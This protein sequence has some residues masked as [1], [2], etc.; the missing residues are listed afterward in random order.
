MEV[1]GEGRSGGVSPTTKLIAIVILG[2]MLLNL[3][4]IVAIVSAVGSITTSTTTTVEATAFSLCLGG[5]DDDEE[6]ST[7]QASTQP[8]DGGLGE[9]QRR[10]AQ[11]YADAGYSRAATA[12]VMGNLQAESHFDPKL[13]EYGGGGGFGLAQWTPRSK[14]RAWFDA[15]GLKDKDDGDL[16]G[17]VKMLIS[18]AQSSFMD[19]PDWSMVNNIE[20]K[21]SAY[22][23]WVTAKDSKTATIAYMAGWERP[24]WTKR[25]EE[26]RVS[27][28]E[29]YYQLIGSISFKT[30]DGK[31]PDGSTGGG[32]SGSSDGSG[33]SD[34][35]GDAMGIGCDTNDR[36]D[37]INGYVEWALKTAKDDKVGYSSDPRKRNLNPDVDCSSF[38]HNALTRG[39]AF[40]VPPVLAFN[41]TNEAENLAKWGF[42][43]VGGK[44]VKI[45]RG[46]ILLKP[47]EGNEGHTEIAVNETTSVG[48]HGDNGHPEDGDQDGNE[49]SEAKLWKG[50]TEVWRYPGKDDDGDGGDATFG[51]VGGAPTNRH[52]FGW[53]CDTALRICHDGDFGRPSISWGGDY[54]CYWYWLARSFV[55][56]D[57][58]I[59]NPMT[60]W[61]G[62]LA[63]E[64]GTRPGWTRSDSPK[65]GAGVSFIL[66]SQG[67][68]HVAVVEKVES[69][70][71]GWKMMI[72]EGN[73]NGTGSWNSYN[74]RWLTKTQYEAGGGQGFFWKTS[75]KGM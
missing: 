13:G 62:Q 22:E 21:S 50:Y 54:Q 37:R 64:V 27:A 2:T 30:P 49:V 48:A 38:V 29:K 31:A 43:K 73:Y 32:P 17:Q 65:P 9:N 33:S 71:S 3:V 10:V 68:N 35:S 42:E 40:D 12:G 5:S 51:S 47:L 66:P 15:N 8:T 57:G 18:T 70:P 7:V 6:G 75:W 46:D 4:F 69:D 45:E 20:K 72:S 34:D 61:G 25:N 55:L 23:T 1:K 74:T 39:G 56:H 63:A 60:A 44:D 41:T 16:D 53:M 59:Q 52:D 14:I 11:A 36:D 28:A 19:G 58:D 26:A 67:I 24:D